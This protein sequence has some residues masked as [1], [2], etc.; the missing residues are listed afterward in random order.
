MQSLTLSLPLGALKNVS[1]CSK[2]VPAE[3]VLLFRVLN[4]DGVMDSLLERDY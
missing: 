1:S 2:T 3:L 4:I